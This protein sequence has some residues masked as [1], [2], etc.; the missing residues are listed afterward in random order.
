MKKILSIILFLCCLGAEAQYNNEWIDY[1]KTYYKFN[2]GKDGIFRIPDSVLQSVG[3]QNIPAEQFQ[4]WKN[5]I[6]VPIYTSAVTG[7]LG[8]SGYIEFWGEMNDGKLDRL[9]YRN[10]NEQLSDK[11][12]LYTDT[13]SYFLTVNPAGNNLRLVPTENNVA[14]NTLPADQYFMYTHNKSFKNRIN[15]GYAGIVGEYVYSSSYDRGEGYTSNDIRPANPLNET[16]NNLYP[17][18]GGPDGTFFISAFGNANNNRNVRVQV[19]NTQLVDVPMNSFFDTKQQVPLPASL[20]STGSAAVRITN[21]SGNVN[22]RMVVGKYELTY[23][24]QFNFGNSTN[25][26]FELDA[27]LAGNYLRISNF[28]HG[29]TDTL[30][31]LYDLTNFRRYL[32]DKSQAG[33]LQFV[34]QPSLQKRKLVLVNERRSNLTAVT[35]LNERNFVNYAASEWQGDYMIISNPWLY[36]GSNGNPVEAY[37][38]YRASATGGGYNARVYD[39]NQL[40]DQFAF[41]I[42]GHPFSVKNFIKYADDV[43]SAK[44]R[45]V[46]LIGK[47]VSYVQ[48]RSNESNQLLERLNLVPTFG[49][50]ASDNLFTARDN[51]TLARIPIG[52]LSVVTPGE[53][54]IYLEKVK[55]HEYNG[56]NAPN[57]VDGRGWMKNVVHAIGGGDA[58]LTRQIGGYMDQLKQIIEDTLYGG[59]VKSYSKSGVI[60]SQ[61]S[62]EELQILFSEGIGILNYFGHSSASKI[63]FNIERPEEYNNLGKYPLFLVN[64]CLAGD[65][66][67]TDVNRFNAINTLSEDYILANQRGAI[68]FI[69]SSH[70][71]IVSYLNSYLQEFYKQLSTTGY[72]NT[73]GEV[74]SGAFESFLAKWGNDFFARL[75]AEEITLHGDPAVKL[76]MQEKPDY[77]TEDQYIQLPPV[78]TVVDREF[79]VKIGL[80]N[81]GKAV[82]DSVNITIQR[83][84]PQGELV[85][86]AEVRTVITNTDSLLFTIPINPALEKGENKIIVTLDSDNEVD[87]VSETNNYVAKTFY[88]IENEVIPVYPYRFSIV[89]KANPVFFASTADPLDKGGTF[90]MEIDTTQLF[91]SPFKRVFSRESRGGLIEFNPSLTLSDSTVYYWRVAVQPPPEKEY[92][93]QNS[94]FV[95]LPGSSE[96]FNQSHFFQHLSSENR[97]LT[98]GAASR[99][100]VFDEVMNSL[101]I[102]NGVY[103]TASGTESSYVN[104]INGQDILG[105]GCN[106]DEVIFQVIDPRTFKPWLN[107]FS[108][109]TGLYNS[110]RATCGGGKIHNFQYFLSNSTSRKHA[111]DFIDLIPDGYYVIARSNTNSSPA[112]N[113]FVD[114]WKA[115]TAMHGSGNSLY[116]KLYEQGFWDLDSFYTPRAWSIVFRKNDML[117]FPPRSQMSQNEYDLITMSVNCPSPDTLGYIVS[118]RLGPAKE[119]KQLHWDGYSQETGNDNIEIEVVGARQDNSRHVLATLDEATKSSDVSFIDASEFPFIELRMKNV[120]TVTSTPYQLRY[121]RLNYEPYPEG[122]IAPNIY[123][124][125]KD[126]VDL[127]EM[128]KIGVA[129]KNISDKN[130]DSLKLKLLL[131]DRNNVQHELDMSRQKPLIAGDTIRLEYTLNTKDFPGLNTI[132]A[133]FNPDGDQLEEYLLNN[134]LHKSIFVRPDNFNPLMDVTFDGVHILN[135]DIVSAKPHILVKVKDDSKFLLLDDT[136]LVKIY[137]RYPN[138]VQRQFSFNNDTL[139]F[140]PAVAGADRVDNTATIEFNPDF[141]EDGDYELVISARDRSGN[142]TGQPEYRAAFKVIN[143]PMISNMFNYPNPFTTSTAFVFTLTGSEVPQNIRIQILTV[144]GKIVREITKEELGDI[145]IGRNITEFKWDGTDQYGQKLANGVYLYRVITN[146]NGKSL[147]KYRAE[148]DRTDQF[149]NKGYGKM[150]LMR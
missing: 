4:L 63:E 115:D 30:P 66:F 17:F 34:L 103:P 11:W 111:M 91:D 81:L 58:N 32:G 54:D 35:K 149:F 16:V 72:G 145:K 129:F 51:Q 92:L 136:S 125:A 114:I 137:V 148:G 41:G 53:I 83:Q 96:G 135:N 131:I 133:F 109:A 77:I 90:I 86:I 128:V 124:E 98:L 122:A 87:E 14:G 8:A 107:D 144:T 3:L 141:L 44:P 88:I 52:R 121:W 79:Q 94:S 146:L 21:T 142:S 102:R 10:I 150:Y 113:T 73:V 47:G 13:A 2:I 26:V 120:D 49:Y 9:L 130:F 117:S 65:I 110:I 119:W 123:F 39:I 93:W 74:L 27:N 23:A 99:S 59:N 104:S 105:S 100:W 140:T 12:S 89:N 50:P 95:Y 64:G 76:F 48:A 106:F 46:F 112:G 85:Q 118:P 139:R 33:I 60:A 71:G 116:H 56:I 78:V 36:N 126:T 70:Y 138:G 127:G 43:F 28:N 84:L 1:S 97:G 80:F 147:D 24:R 143:K 31:V 57:T 37:R 101:F 20:L 7:V 22:D 15:H 68:G 25:F 38:Q 45:A 5:G 82:S 132:V 75:H 134:F 19:N 40:I 108:G 6:Q 18:A 42:K 55:E 67:N 69:A 29:N 62:L 61:L